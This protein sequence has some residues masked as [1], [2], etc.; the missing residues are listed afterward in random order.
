MWKTLEQ[1][2]SRCSMGNGLWPVIEEFGRIKTN[3]VILPTSNGRE[4]RIRCVTKADES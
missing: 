3:D 2:M 1:W 4:V